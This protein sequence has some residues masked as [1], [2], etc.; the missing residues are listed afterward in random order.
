[1]D[2]RHLI[3]L[4]FLQPYFIVDKV[5]PHN[6]FAIESKVISALQASR[7]TVGTRRFRKINPSVDASR[8]FAYFIYVF[9]PFLL[10]TRLSHTMGRSLRDYSTIYGLNLEHRTSELMKIVY[11]LLLRIKN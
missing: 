11:L 6:T 4:S 9:E 8:H 10:I 2:Y 1:M 3:F 7:S 5:P